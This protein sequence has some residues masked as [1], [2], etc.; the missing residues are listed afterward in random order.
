MPGPWS[1]GFH[2][3]LQEHDYRIDEIDSFRELQRVDAFVESTA[4]EGF[5]LKLIAYNALSDTED[6]QRLFYAPDR[7]GALASSEVG[8]F[9]PGTWWLLTLS[10]SF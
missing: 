10:S 3:L 5:K 8:H 4:I 6:R 9:R 7:R 2:S 1:A